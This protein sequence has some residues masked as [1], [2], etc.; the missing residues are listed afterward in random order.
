MLAGL[1]KPSQILWDWY[2]WSQLDK[3][4]LYRILAT[5]SAVFV[6]EQACPYLDPDQHDQVAWHLTGQRGSELCAY[7]RLMPPDGRFKTPS[8]GRVL[9]IGRERG[10]GLG[11]ELMERGIQ[12][13]RDRFP[14]QPISVSAQLYLQEFYRSLG[15]QRLGESYDEDG[16]PHV[17]MLLNGE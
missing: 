14:G 1:N 4:L 11:R 8:I 9:S 13:C 7:L 17:D 10:G 2:S 3:D 15:F 12:G 16:I 6:V 5:R